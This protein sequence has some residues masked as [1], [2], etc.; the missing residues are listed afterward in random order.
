MIRVRDK[1]PRFVN[2]GLEVVPAFVK[3]DLAENES[4]GKDKGFY[5]LNITIPA[6]APV[7][8][9]LGGDEQGVIRLTSDHPR[10]PEVNLKLQFAVTGRVARTS[11][12]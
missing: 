8:S 6:D 9:H 3:V 1:L 7:C 12:P 2:P 10:L 4:L 5:F 11:G